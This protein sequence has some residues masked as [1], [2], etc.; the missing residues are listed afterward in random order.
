MTKGLFPVGGPVDREDLV[1]REEFIVSLVNR[2]QEGQSV[3][4]AGPRRI[5]KTS[6]AREVLRRLKEK[7][8]YTAA[9]DFFRFS[10]KRD[11]AYSLINACLENRTGI[12]KTNGERDNSPF[13]WASA[14]YYVPLL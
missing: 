11:F 4:L 7:G 12:K 6:V 1:G 5:G 8:A 3:M 2:L 13:W 14:G 10:G 9:V